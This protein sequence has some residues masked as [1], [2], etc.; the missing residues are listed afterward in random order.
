MGLF[1]EVDSVEKQCK[2]IINLDDVSE[3]APLQAGGC[4]LFLS[5]GATYKVTNSYELFKQ[6]AMQTV[7]ADDIAKKYPKAK[8]DSAPLEIPKL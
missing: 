7:T 8:K 4:V 6:F 2:V 5:N 3:I 1:V